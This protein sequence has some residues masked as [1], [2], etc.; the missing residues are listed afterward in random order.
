[1][2][3]L[4]SRRI[5]DADRRVVP[6]AS[7]ALRNALLHR[8]GRDNAV[9][10]TD[11]FLRSDPQ[12][13]GDEILH[14]LGGAEMI[15]RLYDEIGI[16]QPA[17]PVVPIAPGSRRFRNRRRVCRNDAAGLLE[18]A[19][20]EGNRRTDDGVLPFIGYGEVLISP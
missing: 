3:H 4:A 2:L 8:V 6:I 15:E 16:A 9:D 17:M 13:K 7:E 5:S 1:V 20:L 11:K 19:E 12:N 10:W 14:G 18:I